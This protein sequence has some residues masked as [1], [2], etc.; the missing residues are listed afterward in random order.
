MFSAEL[1]FH[2]ST[3]FGLVEVTIPAEKCEC[4]DKFNIRSKEQNQG[5]VHMTHERQFPLRSQ[6]IYSSL[7]RVYLLS[8][9]DGFLVVKRFDTDTWHGHRKR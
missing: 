8:L 9:N 2:F 1:S 7:N 5:L 3:H 4:Q 6:S